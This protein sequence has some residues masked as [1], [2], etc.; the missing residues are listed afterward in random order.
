MQNHQEF[1]E[2]FIKAKYKALLE[3]KESLE[4][5]IKNQIQ[6]IGR[7]AKVC[8]EVAAEIKLK[9]LFSKR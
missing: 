1:F 6:K 9:T 5:D 3:Y 2:E 7:M 4:Q 8:P